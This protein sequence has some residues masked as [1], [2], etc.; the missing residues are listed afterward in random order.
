MLFQREARV[1]S[2][3]YVTRSLPSGIFYL[4]DDLRVLVAVFPGEY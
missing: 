3:L 1:S 4:G 2:G